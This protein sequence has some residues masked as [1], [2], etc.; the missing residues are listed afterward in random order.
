MGSFGEAFAVVG[1]GIGVDVFVIVFVVGFF[2]LRQGVQ[3]AELLDVE[4]GDAL[5]FGLVALN[6]DKIADFDNLA[7]DFLLGILVIEHFE[8]RE[9]VDREGHHLV[10]RPFVKERKFLVKVLNHKAFDVVAARFGCLVDNGDDGFWVVLAN[11]QDILVIVV[12]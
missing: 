8:A 3:P 10:A 7:V 5:A 2:G 1:Q 9:G 4:G 6:A 11:Q 12:R